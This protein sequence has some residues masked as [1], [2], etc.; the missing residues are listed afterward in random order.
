MNKAIPFLL[1]IFWSTLLYSQSVVVDG[2]TFSADGKTLIKY[3]TDKFYKEYIIPEGTEIID[4]KAFVGA[5]IGKVTLP[6]TLTHIKDSAFY[7]GQLISFLQGNSL[8]L[9]IVFEPMI[10]VLK[11]LRAILIVEY[12]TMVLFILKMEKLYI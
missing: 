5:K 10:G 4:R 2:A 6:T 12:R 3:P 11:L 8:L 9:E 1:F 7:N